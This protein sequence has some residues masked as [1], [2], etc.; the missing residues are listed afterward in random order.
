MS[1]SAEKFEK[2][3]TTIQDLLMDKLA[4]HL[5]SFANK[6]PEFMPKVERMIDAADKL[7]SWFLDNP[8]EHAGELMLA[9]IGA[10]LSKA[11]IGAAVKVALERVIEARFAG[12]ATGSAVTSIAG[13]ARALGTGAVGAAGSVGAVG[14]V[15][16]AA[17]GGALYGTYMQNDAGQNAADA[18]A[19]YAKDP[20]AYAR[21]VAARK[22]QNKG[23]DPNSREYAANLA[24]IGG[25]GG[26]GGAFGMTPE[27]KA[28]M[29]KGAKNPEAMQMGS[30]PGLP[31]LSIDQVDLQKQISAAVVGGIKDGFAKN[32]KGDPSHPSRGGPMSGGP[33]GGT[34]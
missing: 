27:Q 16:A 21:E 2:A 12:N 11:G 14:G 9:K 34:L 25:G 26:T 17:V 18:K 19:M 8:L 6:L 5:E 31:K 33:R 3:V 1:T 29:E 10:D 4:P 15:A 30:A 23:L 24:Y 7:A 20:A 32:D 28:I 13:G 22:Q